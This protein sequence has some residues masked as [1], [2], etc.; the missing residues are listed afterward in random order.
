MNESK[1]SY[2]QL[3]LT[4]QTASRLKFVNVIKD[5]ASSFMS[6]SKI[7]Q[8]YV[9]N[10]FKNSCIN[11]ILAPLWVAE[12]FFGSALLSLL[13]TSIISDEVCNSSSSMFQDEDGNGM[14]KLEDEQGEVAWLAYAC[15]SKNNRFVQNLNI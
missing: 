7:Y 1:Y 15:F 14:K 5:I 8:W 4:T 6:S 11:D 10:L 2:Y 13:V 3:A 9:K 12:I